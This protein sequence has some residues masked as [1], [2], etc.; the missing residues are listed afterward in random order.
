[1]KGIIL[2]ILIL[3]NLSLYAQELVVGE[4]V[5]ISDDE[6]K[7]SFV[8]DQLIYNAYRDA[9]SK[10]FVKI[11]YDSNLFWQKYQES[12]D[13]YFLGIEQVY[14][15]KYKL[16]DT[17]VSE[18]Q[19]KL[20]R[21]LLRKRKLN[22][23]KKFRRLDRLFKK[24]FIHK[25]MSRSVSNPSKRYLSIK[26]VVNRKA[27]NKMYLSLTGRKEVASYERLFVG[28]VLNAQNFNWSDVGMESYD[29]LKDVLLKEWIKWFEKRNL[30][31]IKTIEAAP[32]NLYVLVNDQELIPETFQNSLFASIELSVKK[33]DGNPHL[34]EFTIDYSGRVLL[35]N[36][37]R[38]SV[39]DDFKIDPIK[40][41]YKLI[42]PEEVKNRIANYLYRLPLGNFDK[43]A[44]I[45]DN[46]DIK[47]KE[48]IL[49]I[50]QVPTLKYVFDL[51]KMLENRGV[52]YRLSSQ[53][54]QFDGKM[55]NLKLEYHGQ[56]DAI[57]SLLEQLSSQRFGSKYMISLNKDTN[58]LQFQPIPVVD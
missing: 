20:G 10:E 28:V 50:S 16:D 55:A 41:S 36:L 42:A 29:G 26:A 25:A 37:L 21:Q 39:V 9:I 58:E 33:T 45:S 8:K 46:I 40:Q 23:Q 44:K 2:L 4:G 12:F 27:L 22:E 52:R 56:D 19:K 31:Q 38:N 5:F 32:N 15:K 13:T 57:D 48:F 54:T 7:L 53:V 18:N 43:V 49:T 30:K 47:G 6:D 34:R 3:C 35:R 1:M 11:G 51:Q 14:N 17:E 24:W